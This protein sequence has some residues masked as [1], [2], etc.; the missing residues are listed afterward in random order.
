MKISSTQIIRFS[1]VA[2]YLINA[3]SWGLILWK[4]PFTTDTVY[5]HY[6]VY[7]GI[8]LTGSWYGVLWIPGSG[9]VIAVVNTIAVFVLKQLPSIVKYIILG[10]TAVMQCALLLASVLIVLLNN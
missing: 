2:I 7:F 9:A 5:L 10:A 4:L 8:D 6:N 3:F 1:V